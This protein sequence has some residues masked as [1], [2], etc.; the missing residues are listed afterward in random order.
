MSNNRQVVY[1]IM[2]RGRVI[3]R[4]IS[5]DDFF[6]VMEDM[7]QSFYENGQPHPDEITYETIE[8]N[9]TNGSSI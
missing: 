2:C 8:V 5:Q 1:N 6:D 4:E 3:H 7:A 9:Q